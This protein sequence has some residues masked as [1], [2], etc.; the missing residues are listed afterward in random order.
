MEEPGE[1]CTVVF[2]LIVTEPTSG[3]FT[4]HPSLA[5]SAI[6]YKD[7]SALFSRFLP[8]G[9]IFLNEVDD[10]DYFKP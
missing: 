1:Q 9:E 4:P 6:I 2:A 3:C 7:D 8:G 5:G 10:Y